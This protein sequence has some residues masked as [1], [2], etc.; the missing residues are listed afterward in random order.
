M[1]MSPVGFE[2]EQNNLMGRKFINY[3]F[4]PMNSTGCIA[5]HCSF[6]LCS[7]VCQHPC[8]VLSAACAALPDSWSGVTEDFC[9]R[10][11]P[12]TDLVDCGG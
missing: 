11:G 8:C 10:V 6:A 1:L 3:S 5:L 9:C 4:L 2:T 12:N 7:L